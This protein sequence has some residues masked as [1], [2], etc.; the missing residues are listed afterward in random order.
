[1]KDCYYSKYEPIF[2]SWRIDEELG[3]GAEGY[4]FRIWREDSLGHKFYSALKAITIPKGGLAE[5]ESLMATGMSREEA[6]EYFDSVLDST[7]QEF[8]LLEKLKGNSNIVSYED[9]EIFRND[10]GFGWDI[11]IRLE[12]LTPLVRHS[13]YHQMNESEIIRMA[14][15]LCMG[16]ETCRKFGIVHRDIKPENIFI[17]AA[18]NYK[19]GDFGIARIIEESER[20]LSRKGTYSYMA[21]EIYW[22][23][24]YD[25]TVDIYSLG[26]VMY[27]YMNDG[28]LPFMPGYPTPADYQDEASALAKRMSGEQL[29]EP[30]NGSA[31]LKAV[32]MKACAYDKADRYTNAWE[33]LKDLEAVSAETADVRTSADKDVPPRR[34]RWAFKI[35]AAVIALLILAAGAVY[36]MIPKEVEDIQTSGLRDGMEIYIDEEVAPTYTVKPDWFK[37]EPVSFSTSDESVLAVDGAGRLYAKKPGK[38]VIKMNA[39][40]YSEEAAVNVVPKV[41]TIKGI[42]ETIAMTTGN[43]LK[44]EPV[45]LPE[46]FA[47]EPVTYKTSD[48]KVAEV[49][50]DGTITAVAAGETEITVSAGGT[51]TVSEINVSDPVVYV[52]PQSSGKKSSG[53][54]KK[55]SSG[56]ASK[57]YFDSGD[58]E[59]F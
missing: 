7:A 25:H 36:A 45:L 12:E 28:R 2:G 47:K 39:K 15:D 10:N 11:L 51:S 41:K 4:L 59:S 21:P 31:A 26:L 35:T 48:K 16:L 40:E 27:R 54:K 44:L 23:K 50:D 33:M 5:L 1:M 6:L 42:D 58:D 30:R 3:S 13:I 49:S 18:G 55:S 56:K 24:E 46:K 43:T 9:H 8:S 37:D 17:S 22:G 32:I 57:G 29:P 20:S 19:I 34:N 14:T 38:A 52:P 53:S